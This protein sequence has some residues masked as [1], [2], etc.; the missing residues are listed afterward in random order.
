MSTPRARHA[1]ADED[2]LRERDR[3]TQLL[4]LLGRHGLRGL[5][6]RLGLQ[7]SR[8]EGLEAAR[9]EAVVAVLREV[10]PVG[11]KFGQILAMRSD[12]L[13]PDWIRALSTLQDRVPA[14]PFDAI[15]PV[16]ADAIGG[17]LESCFASFDRA[18]LA[19]ASIAQVHAATLLDGRS[20][21]VKVRRP[22]IERVVDADLRLLRRL[23]RAAERRIPEVARLKPDELLRYFAESLDRE[24]DLS[25]EGRSSDSIGAFLAP[26]G[27]RTAWFEW[28]ITGRRVNVQERLTG[29]AATDLDAARAAGLDLQAIAR[30]YAQAMLRMIIF[31]GQF[32]ADPHP[33]NVILLDDGSLGLIDFG[34]V[35]TLLPQRRD[36][37]VRL[38]LSIAADDVAGVADILM[39]W[40]GD[41][42]IERPRLE[43]ALG[44][45]IDSFKNVVLDQIDLTQTFQ[46]VFALLR[47]FQL[48]LPPDLALVLRT[49]LTAEGFVRRID[50]SF[51]I[52]AELAPIARELIAERTSH[53]RLR[54]E[55]RKLAAA[56]GRAALSTPEII[57]QIEKVARTGT[58]PVSINAKDLRAFERIARRDQ[59]DEPPIVPA[60]LLISAA[61]LADHLP[62]LA[63]LSAGLALAMV[64]WGFVRRKFS[65]R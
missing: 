64:V 51:D 38:A 2:R 35:G 48:A 8:D 47:E 59:H 27:V 13:G 58:I 28:E 25:A 57:G 30:S 21:I 33:G 61:I 54:K 5:A 40:A 34:A 36:E 22:G 44:Q 16:V 45:L 24:M 56:L 55:A 50:P 3:F 31:N 12:L 23:A 41:P 9:P 4:G 7:G 17:P 32:H 11:V 60:A 6:A 1:P 20:V 18:P 46:Q 42:D 62:L 14:L 29:I 19:A 49:L 39:L 65:S 37:L 26:L 15:E 52:A 53:V 63:A 43:L 10:G